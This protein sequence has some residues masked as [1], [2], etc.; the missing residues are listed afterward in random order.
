MYS[1]G[2]VRTILW[3]LTFEGEVL[4]NIKNQSI[5]R[6]LCS[7]PVIWRVCYIPTIL[8]EAPKKLLNMNLSA[9][10]SLAEIQ[11]K[12][13]ARFAILH[14]LRWL[15]IQKYPQNKSVLSVQWQLKNENELFVSCLHF[16]NKFLKQQMAWTS[17]LTD[18]PWF[19]Q[20]KPPIHLC[21]ISSKM[22]DIISSWS[23]KLKQISEFKLNLL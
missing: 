19:W 22:Q 7:K 5:F 17:Y 9:I 6:N 4:Q 14:K 3:N 12:F 1:F 18:P 20:V 2:K 10:L 16:W 8:I 13:I 15:L 23:T 21:S 11:F